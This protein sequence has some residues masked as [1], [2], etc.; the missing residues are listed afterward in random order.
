MTNDLATFSFNTAIARLMEYV[1][2]IYAYEAG[3][4]K[5]HA[6]YK[7]C[8][9]DLVLLFAPFAPHFCEELWE[10]LGEKYSVFNQ[11]Y[12]TYDEKATILD[13]IE[14]AVQINSKLRGRIMVANNASKEDIE[15]AAVAEVAAQLD[16][17]PVKKI[18]IVPKRLVNLIV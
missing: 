16:G 5:K 4:E 14:L 18:I 17:K 12:P 3:V 13:E 11:T 9:K 1:N 6:I 2:A 7:D 8:A 15:K 10:V